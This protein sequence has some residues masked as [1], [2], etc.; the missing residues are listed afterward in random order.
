MFNKET[1]E[2]V[3]KGI[4]WLNEK[5]GIW[6]FIIPVILAS[7]VIFFLVRAYRK[8]STRNSR[9][10]LAVFAAAYLFG[11][12]TIFIG[13]DFMGTSTAM[14]G[15]FGLWLVSLLLILD[16]FFSWTEIKIH[17]NKLLQILSWLLIFSGIFLYPLLEI[18]LGFTYPRMVF[19]G[20]ECPTTIAL[21]GLFI[22]SV[23]RVNKIL[24][25]LISLNAVFT[26]GSVALSGAPFD[27]MYAGAGV[28]GVLILIVYFKTIFRVKKLKDG[29]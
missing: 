4:V 27:F 16:I 11:G 1:T 7:A 25:V 17:N 2:Q 3:L 13:K 10:V 12:W 22:G 20:A 23:P 24:F 6:S 14:A 19:F 9:I 26:G 18:I 15:A 21:I 28:L 29:E 8:P 5:M